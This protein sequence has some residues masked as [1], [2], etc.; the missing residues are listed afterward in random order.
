MNKEDA[1]NI[2]EHWNSL[3]CPK[4]WGDLVD[5]AQKLLEAGK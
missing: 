3:G 4:G 2:L 1:E 5:E